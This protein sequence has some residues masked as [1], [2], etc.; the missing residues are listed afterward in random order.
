M[1]LSDNSQQPGKTQVPG[2]LLGYGLQYSRMLSLLLE[3]DGESIVS[4]EVFEDVGV[5][6]GHEVL[7]SQAKSSTTKNPVSNRAEPLWKTLRNWVDAIDCGQL[8]VDCTYSSYMYL[9]ILRAKF[10]AYFPK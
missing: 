5:Q 9:A 7:A 2:Q 8:N 4:L 10:V 3:A 6:N 1:A